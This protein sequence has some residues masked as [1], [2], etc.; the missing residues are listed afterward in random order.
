MIKELFPTRVYIED[1]NFDD[2]FTIT[3]TAVLK[4]AHVENMADKPDYESACEEMFLFT[5]ERLA[6]YP[7]LN[8]LLDIFVQGFTDLLRADPGD[9]EYY[10]HDLIISRIRDTII[11][12]NTKRP[13]VKL[14][15]MKRGGAKKTHIHE[16]CC[17]FGVFYPQDV[18]NAVKGAMLQL[19]SPLHLTQH[20][21]A[22]EAEY[23]VE[24]KKNRLI[25][26]PN[27]VWHSVS[28]YLSDKERMCVVVSLP[29][30]ILE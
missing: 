7:E 9:P 13:W 8:K 14:A 19:Q 2:N 5:E 16:Q 4:E 20:H 26:A 1:F 21:F 18:D 28:E 23:E 27:Y 30:S 3:L 12:K 22:S 29:N 10:Q 6:K 11:G 25:I 24:T 15:F 17:A